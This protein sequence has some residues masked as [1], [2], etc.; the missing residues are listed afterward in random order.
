MK[1]RVSV[2][3]ICALVALS[4]LLSVRQ[5]RRAKEHEEYLLYFGDRI[6]VFLGDNGVYPRTLREYILWEER[7]TSSP[8]PNQEIEL[9]LRQSVCPLTDHKPQTLDDVDHWADIKVV[10]YSSPIMAVDEAV[11]AYCPASNHRDNRVYVIIHRPIGL[12]AT[13]WRQ[14]YVVKSMS[15]E[16][17]DA[18]LAEQRIA[19]EKV[20]S[21]P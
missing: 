18:K 3:V 1:I 19:F 11:L 2:F 8:D 15:Q 12:K 16:E 9:L 20:A 7:V 10:P 6:T 17:F 13:S 14:H 4:I 5:S 21:K